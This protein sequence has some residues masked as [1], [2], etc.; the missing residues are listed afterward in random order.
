M[1]LGMRVFMKPD[2]TV[3]E[4]LVIKRFFRRLLEPVLV[5]LYYI[6][7]FKT[8]YTVFQKNIPQLYFLT[9]NLNLECF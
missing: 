9:P 2:I 4:N 8:G 6:Q 3:S 7:V 5:H 1:G